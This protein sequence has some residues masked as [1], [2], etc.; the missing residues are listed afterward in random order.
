ML[1]HF[2]FSLRNNYRWQLWQYDCQWIGQSFPSRTFWLYCW[3]RLIK[4][5]RF[6]HVSFNKFPYSGWQAKAC[7]FKVPGP[8]LYALDTVTVCMTKASFK[9]NKDTFLRWW[10]YQQCWA[11]LYAETPAGG[12]TLECYC[13]SNFHKTGFSQ[14][15]KNILWSN[16]IAGYLL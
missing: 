14:K 8:H 15:D 5:T 10:R 4:R 9:N 16:F 12:V 2:P 3:W 1:T 13:S 6:H 7:S 11:V